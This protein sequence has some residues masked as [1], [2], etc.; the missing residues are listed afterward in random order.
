MSQQNILVSIGTPT[1]ADRMAL[2]LC[3]AGGYP[4]PCHPS[5]ICNGCRAQAAAVIR[6][7]AEQ[8]VPDCSA[9]IGAAGPAHFHRC[10]KAMEVRAEILARAAE[11]DGHPGTV[12]TVQGGN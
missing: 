1:P 9:H 8:V 7:L 12:Q 11:L 10:S 3:R 6:E 4:G 5:E 2:A